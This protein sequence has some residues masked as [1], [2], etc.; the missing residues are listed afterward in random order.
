MKMAGVAEVKAR[1]S[2]YL[3]AELEKAFV[4]EREEGW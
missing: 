3:T 4:A 2:E 1:L